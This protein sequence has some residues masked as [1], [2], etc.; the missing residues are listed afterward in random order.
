MGG[1]DEMLTQNRESESG[2]SVLG[3]DTMLVNYQ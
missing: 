1:G 2:V 3:M